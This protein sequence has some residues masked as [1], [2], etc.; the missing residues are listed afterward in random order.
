MTRNSLLTRRRHG[1]AARPAPLAIVTGAASG[2]GRSIALELSRFELALG[3]CDLNEPGLLEVQRAA[4]RNGAHCTVRALDVT[5][6]AELDDFAAKLTNREGPVRVLVNC[7]GV[8]AMGC[9]RDSDDATL[10][11]VIDV[12]LWGVIHACRAF[13]PSM[14]AQAHGGHIVNIASMAGLAPLPGAA[15]Y[16]TSKFAVV[17]FSESLRA[18]LAPHGIEVSVVCP[19]FIRSGIADGP[20]YSGRVRM[21]GDWTTREFLKKLH[22]RLAAR[23]ERVARQ[24][25]RAIRRRRRVVPVTGIAWATY[26]SRRLA[27]GLYAGVLKRLAPRFPH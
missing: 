27:P 3:L 8:G 18:E 21:F 11:R 2:I 4:S 17:G 15:I 14:L 23:P 7:A 19:G 13:L 12:N 1:Q 10:Q 5:S 24:V 22:E 26:L 20:H 16:N 25:I 9:I 6:R